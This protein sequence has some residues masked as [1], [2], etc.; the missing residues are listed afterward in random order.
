MSR[1][2]E[3]II[4]FTTDFSSYISQGSYSTFLP[5]ELDFESKWKCG[6]LDFSI[7]TAGF[8]EFVKSIYILVDFCET[9]T[10]GRNDSL[11][12]LKKVYLTKEEKLYEFANPLYITV[13]QNILKNYNI[14]FLNSALRE[15][16]SVELWPIELTLHL[17][18]DD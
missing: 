3:H 6:V 18:K 10:V 17:I 9:S 12:I 14:T 4:Y 7:G 8:N 1:R 15:I 16:D 2:K 13:K 11:P 5:F